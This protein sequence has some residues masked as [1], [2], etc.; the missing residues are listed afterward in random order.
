MPHEQI[1]M[2]N[3]GVKKSQTLKVYQKSGGYAS[4][5]KA[6]KMPVEEL[7]DFVAPPEG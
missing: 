5:E 1:L 2:R 7:I 4:A 3:V 6:L